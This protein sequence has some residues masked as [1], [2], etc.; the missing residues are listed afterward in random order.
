MSNRNVFVVT[1]SIL[2]DHHGAQVQFTKSKPEQKRGT[3]SYNLQYSS[4]A[5][6]IIIHRRYVNTTFYSE[7]FRSPSKL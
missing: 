3:F 6:P 4:E 2:I 7:V 1:N 5:V